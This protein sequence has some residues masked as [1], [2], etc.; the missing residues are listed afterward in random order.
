[1]GLK[2]TGKRCAASKR[3]GVRCRG[4]LRDTILDW[5]DELPARELATAERVSRSAARSVGNGQGR[6]FG[7]MVD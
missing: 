3:R 1:M 5:E 4:H 7:A 6:E 2:R